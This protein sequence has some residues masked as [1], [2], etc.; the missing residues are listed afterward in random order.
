M[1]SLGG[2]I[3][4]II[5]SLIIGYLSRFFEPKSKLLG[6]SPHNFLFN[7]Q[8][9]GV[10]IQTNSLTVQNWGRKPAE[11]IEIIHK[12]RPD[13]FEIHPSIVYT[14]STNPNGEH[15][16]HV[17]TLGP[18]EWFLVQLLSYKTVPQLQNVRWKNGQC[19]WVQIVPQRVLPRP[20]LVTLKVLM[21]VGIG[22]IAYWL[23]RVVIF[24]NS[25]IH[26]FQ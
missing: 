14:E 18:K 26:L 4:T 16:I 2:Y 6:W 1:D 5:V 20:F 22:T 23:I 7:L 24:V 9:E 11:D 19:K 12:T 10:V 17:K 3:A 25:Q 15:V 13:F 21:L 8:K